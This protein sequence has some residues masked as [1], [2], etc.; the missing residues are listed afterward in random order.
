MRRALR[1]YADTSVFGG[2]QD[3][4]FREP[5]RRFFE[6][7]EAGKYELVVSRVTFDELVGAPDAVQDLVDQLPPSALTRLSRE[8]LREAR[9]L[10]QAYLDAGILGYASAADAA[11]VAA[12]TVAEADLL[13][14]WNF[15]HIVNYERIRKFNAINALKGYAPIEIRSPLE[16]VYGHEGEDV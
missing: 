7:V 4:E 16:V 3:D 1:V 9:T 2:T 8:V 11:H 6:Q 14:S 10:A 15:R 13:V 5:S 12:A